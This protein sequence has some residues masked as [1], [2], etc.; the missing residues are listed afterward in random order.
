LSP[1][2]PA[3]SAPASPPAPAPLP[4]PPPA[5]EQAPQVGAGVPGVVEVGVGACTGVEIVGTVIGCD[6]QTGAPLEVELPG[7]P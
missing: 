5:P 2:A 7:L 6:P 4:A 1:S 3:P